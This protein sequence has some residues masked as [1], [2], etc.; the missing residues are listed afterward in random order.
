MKGL[1]KATQEGTVTAL[2]S[3]FGGDVG[4]GGVTDTGQIAA[5]AFAFA[6]RRIRPV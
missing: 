5:E 6:L 2:L 1:K 4:A 3:E